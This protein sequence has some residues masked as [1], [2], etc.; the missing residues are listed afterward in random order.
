ME[1]T[2]YFEISSSV[3]VLCTFAFATWGGTCG[4]CGTGVLMWTLPSFKQFSK[5]GHYFLYFHSKFKD[6]D[7][8]C[9]FS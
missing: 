9:V 8:E 4:S 2:I 5:E 7:P 3:F 6:L 1:W